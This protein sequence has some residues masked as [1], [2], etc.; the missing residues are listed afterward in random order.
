MSWRI[1]SRNENTD[2]PGHIGLTPILRGCDVYKFNSLGDA[3]GSEHSILL[4]EPHE[5]N[6]ARW[7]G[8]HDGSTVGM[9]IQTD[10]GTLVS[11]QS[12][13]AVM[14]RNLTLL[15]MLVAVNTAYFWLSHLS[16]EGKQILSLLSCACHLWYLSTFGSFV[17]CTRPS[18][19]CSP[20]DV[21]GSHCVTLVISKSRQVEEHC[22]ASA[23]SIYKQNWQLFLIPVS[24]SRKHC[25]GEL[26]TLSCAGLAFRLCMTACFY[27]ISYYCL[28]SG[29]F[30]DL[31]LS[32]SDDVQK[33]I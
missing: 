18:R 20:C 32:T 27:I 19:H 4:T 1:C 10:Q 17:T 12:C 6:A 3:C 15:V 31:I 9:R 25:S 30:S 26:L 16:F 21:H 29:C 7:T 13:V 28:F 33:S 5:E 14:S 11:R 23:Q 8:C 2:G 24:F 22:Y